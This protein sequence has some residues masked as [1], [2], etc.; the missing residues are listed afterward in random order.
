MAVPGGE[1]RCRTCAGSG[2]RGRVGIYEWMHV[3]DE[4]RRAINDRK[5]ATELAGIARRHGMRP[6]REDGEIKVRAGITTATEVARV[7]QL[8]A[9]A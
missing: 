7:C 5:D 3:N 2:F 6:L 4:L 1:R 9:V 8:D